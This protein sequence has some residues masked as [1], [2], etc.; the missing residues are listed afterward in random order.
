MQKRIE[1]LGR[2]DPDTPADTAVP[3][4]GPASRDEFLA[5]K[6]GNAITAVAGLH[7]YFYS[8]EEHSVILDFR[9]WILD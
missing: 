6:R 2:L 8:V 1:P 9:F 4:G 3:A 5:P 7:L